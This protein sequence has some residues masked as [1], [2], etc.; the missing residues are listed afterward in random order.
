MYYSS[1]VSMLYLIS[2][3]WFSG[4]STKHSLS[5]CV[6]VWNL[7]TLV[8]A[9]RSNITQ[10]LYFMYMYIVKTS[11][12]TQYTNSILDSGTCSERDLKRLCWPTTLD[13]TDRGFLCKLN[14]VIHI[15]AHLHTQFTIITHLCIWDL[16]PKYIQFTK[17]VCPYR[18]VLCNYIREAGV[19]TERS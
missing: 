4:H 18:L 2:P 1:Q 10:G 19:K 6:E 7:N 15:I 8:H 3:V 17:G 5:V 13:W 14:N 16:D 9:H 11:L 12:T